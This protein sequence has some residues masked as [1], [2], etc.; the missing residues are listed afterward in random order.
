MNETQFLEATQQLMDQVEEA[1]ARAGLDA[2][3]D[4]EGNVMTIEFDNGEQVVIN[5][6][7]PTQQMWLASRRGGLHFA[8]TDGAWRC[9]R[10]AEDFWPALSRVV[11]QASGADA[12]LSA[13]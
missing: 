6:H 11:S 13:A 3:V 2:D 8:L 4:R 7:G 1:L 10:T 12:A 9:T 5:R